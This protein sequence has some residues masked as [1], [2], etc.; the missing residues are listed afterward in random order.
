MSNASLVISRLDQTIS[1]FKSR[2]DV[3]ACDEYVNRQH[4]GNN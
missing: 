1:S 4:S 3:K 2:V